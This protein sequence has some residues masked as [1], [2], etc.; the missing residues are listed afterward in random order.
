L[1]DAD[2][3]V[4]D[5]EQIE[6]LA[7]RLADEAG[8]RIEAGLRAEWLVEYKGAERGKREFSNPVSELDRSIEEFVR[9]TILE[10]FPSHAVVGEELDEGLA[11]A[12]DYLWVVDPLDGTANFLN[13][14]PMF[15]CSVGVLFR[16]RPV[17]GAIW[18]ASSHLLHPG[19]YHARAGGGLHLDGVAIE[20]ASREGVRRRL[21]ASPG[22]A[23]AGGS[24]WDARVTGS[25]AIEC[26]YV[27]VGVFNSA[28]FV[29]PSIW[30]V[31]AGV[32]IAR[33][34]GLTVS[35]RPSRRGGWQDFE[36]FE[37]PS[38]GREGRPPTIRDW[39]LALIIGE[40]EV[41][42]VRMQGLV[43][44]RRWRWPWARARR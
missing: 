41:V 24:G 22:G 6:A 39:R 4:A 5:L 14:F 35:V 3:G 40:P 11:E 42:T 20:H 25:M 10:Q 36:T 43:R 9:R 17:V 29:A 8:Q 12:P 1:S 13:G 23:A 16:G 44:R 33:A 7:R 34:A 15:A 28:V 32:V 18:C 21:G 31:A 37:S 27:A 19:V 38:R 30:D 2:V 26:A